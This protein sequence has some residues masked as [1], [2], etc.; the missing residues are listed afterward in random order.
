MKNTSFVYAL[1]AGAIVFGAA[2]LA[3]AG[4]VEENRDQ[5]LKTRSCP[6]CNLS[7]VNL[8]RAEL[9]GA[10]LQGADLTNARFLLANLAGA[11]LQG[12]K[13][14]GAKFGG[15]DLAAADLRGADLEASALN[16]AYYARAAFDPELAAAL[17]QG[18]KDA[19]GSAAEAAAAE[20]PPAPAAPPAAAEP[21]IKPVPAAKPEP[22]PAPEAAPVAAS[23]ATKA[24][25]PSHQD[26]ADDDAA[27]TIPMTPAREQESVAEPKVPGAAG[28]DAEATAG[29]DVQDIPLPAAAPPVKTAS[30]I[31][32]IETYTPPPEPEA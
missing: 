18:G 30:P 26:F 3:A 10:D 14:R 20:E 22:V 2:D 8:S 7:G 32:A 9:S 24:V 19:A 27:A 12:T 17:R 21:E 11:N 15:A 1:L 6:S 29:D 5:L 31:A 28:T 4:T 13:L 25:E 23:S 16:G